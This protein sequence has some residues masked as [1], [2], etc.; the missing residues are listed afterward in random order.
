MGGWALPGERDPRGR[1]IWY[2]GD[3]S[4]LALE[5]EEDMEVASRH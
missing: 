2:D 5:M 3:S 4:S 1:G